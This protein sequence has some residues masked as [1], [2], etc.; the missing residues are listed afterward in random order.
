MHSI[1]AAAGQPLPR[2]LPPHNSSERGA[3]PRVDLLKYRKPG[4]KRFPIWFPILLF[5][6]FL[7][8]SHTHSYKT[9][10]CSCVLRQLYQKCVLWR[11]PPTGEHME[12]VYHVLPIE[13]MPGDRQETECFLVLLPRQTSPL[14]A[15]ACRLYSLH[16]DRI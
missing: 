8:S 1:L 16:Y 14:T 12:V 10:V 2:P 3:T 4:R 7:H 6:H 15:Y 13:I 11:Y 9:S 5:N